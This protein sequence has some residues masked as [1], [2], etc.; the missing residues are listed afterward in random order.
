MYLQV[1]GW[2]HQ[3]ATV[4]TSFEFYFSQNGLYSKPRAFRPARIELLTFFVFKPQKC[5]ILHYRERVGNGKLEDRKIT[6]ACAH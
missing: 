1:L 4:I 6:I 2:N 3:I 5:R